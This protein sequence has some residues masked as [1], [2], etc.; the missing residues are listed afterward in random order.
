M[1]RVIYR[2]VWRCKICRRRITTWN[3]RKRKY[4]HAQGCAS[5]RPKI[6]L[7]VKAV[8]GDDL[9]CDFS[10]HKVGG[11]KLAKDDP[12]MKACVGWGSTTHIYRVDPDNPSTH[13]KGQEFH[14][15]NFKGKNPPE[16]G[17]EKV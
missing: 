12:L 16:I 5:Y 2:N 1:I 17:W 14:V 3:R 15:V 9:V 13:P 10:E 11:P 7:T 8:K 6:T 4:C